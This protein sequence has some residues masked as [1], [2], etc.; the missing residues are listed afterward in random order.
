MTCSKR[1]YVLRYIVFFI[2]LSCMA[3][4]IALTTLANLGT[5]PI[6]T[7][8][9]VASLGF[10]P[11]IGF[12]TG[13]MNLAL[14]GF[15]IA[16]LRRKFPSEQYLQIPAALLFGSLIDFW[17]YLVPV[18]EPMT[19]THSVVYLAAG[20]LVLAFGIFVEVS[21]DVVV[22]AGEGAVLV[23]AT[24]LRRDFGVIK[25]AF[26]ITLVVLAAALSLLLF[27]KV[28]GVREGTL[29][30]AVLVGILVKFFFGLKNRP[31]KG[32]AA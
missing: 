26:D 6:S 19:Y 7:L 17:M 16:V 20:T 30:S 13:M 23:L 29:I 22:M 32:S 15:Q 14:V 1:K 10:T 25:V 28:Y 9:F 4:G 12:F 11:T 24:K 5:T 8:P 21:A 31:G 3:L 18:P 2:G 27:G